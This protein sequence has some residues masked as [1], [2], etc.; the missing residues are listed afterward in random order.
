MLYRV[1]ITC[2]RFDLTTLMGIG[3][4]CISRCKSNYH[5]ITTTT[6]LSCI[7]Y[8]LSRILY[9]NKYYNTDNILSMYNF[10][11]IIAFFMIMLF[12][13]LYGRVGILLTCERRRD[14]T[15]VRYTTTYV[16]CAYHH[17]S[18][19]FE[20]CSGRGIQHYV[21]KFDSDLLQVGGF[22]RALRFLPPIKLTATI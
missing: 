5:T 1:H 19:E 10:F 20:S 11:K 2:A 22:L 17:W 18:C 8:F 14:R 9:H 12:A 13:R 4:D 15:V 21:I 16:I 6:A 3:T 7:L